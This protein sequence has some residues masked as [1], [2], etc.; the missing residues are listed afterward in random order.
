MSL[1]L[2]D[3]HAAALVHQRLVRI[4]FG[5]NLQQQRRR[6][7]RQQQQDSTCSQVFPEP[8]RTR[9][10]PMIFETRIDK[11]Y[12]YGQINRH[13]PYIF[14]PGRHQPT[15]FDSSRGGGRSA[16]TAASAA[17]ESATKH[18]VRPGGGCW[19]DHLL[20]QRRIRRR[21]QRCE[22]LEGAARRGQLGA[23]VN[24]QCTLA[25]FKS[26]VGEQ[27]AMR[28]GHVINVLL[29]PLPL[30]LRRLY[31]NRVLYKYIHTWPS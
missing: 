21:F 22:L 19:S 3:R 24:T 16:L 25:S 1:K 5:S 15:V 30:L 4:S 8:G 18:L 13:V 11:F 26:A 7:G 20:K 29:L 17:V 2:A 12:G 31:W 14:S 27:R 6:W 9:D 10:V 23:A 28:P